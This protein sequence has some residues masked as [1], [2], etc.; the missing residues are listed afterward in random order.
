MVLRRWTTEDAPPDGRVKLWHEAVAEAYFPLD[1]SFRTPDRFSGVLDMRPTGRLSLSRLRTA[2]MQYERRRRDISATSDEEYL[3][4][5]PLTSAVR[6]E[7]SGQSILCKQGGFI[8][9]RGDAPY[10]F[11]YEEASDLY[12]M[13]VARDVLNERIR[14][15]R[16]LCTQVFDGRAGLGG[17]FT[18]M[19]REV[20][21]KGDISSAAPV[22]ERH[23]LDL[24]ALALNARDESDHSGSA[25][26]TAH[27]ERAKQ[28]IDAR[29]S[30][31]TLSPESIAAAC[32]ISRRYLHDLFRDESTSVA[33]L[34]RERRLA[35]AKELLQA[36]PGRSIADIAYS[37]A[38]SDQAQF[39]RLFRKTYDMTPTDFRRS[40]SGV[41]RA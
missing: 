7:Q 1:L 5:V 15:P 12:V 2:P 24:L 34:I 14:N 28:Y 32:G 11:S 26:R 36:A 13:K 10:R 38:F 20:H 16:R 35:A 19:L 23:L 6:F 17:L 21:A 39:S 9:E 27:R 31:P 29:L 25:V 18:T 8:L 30:D 33:A 3:V 4:T 22:L 41:A 40:A 37:F